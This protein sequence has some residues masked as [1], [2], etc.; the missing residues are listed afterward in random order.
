MRPKVAKMAQDGTNGQIDQKWRGMAKMTKMGQEW[1]K[2]CAKMANMN[3]DG[4][5]WP[6]MSKNDPKWSK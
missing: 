3:K 2:K 4:Q 5:K 6:K 1:Q